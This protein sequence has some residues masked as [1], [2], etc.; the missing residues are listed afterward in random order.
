MVRVELL[1]R[2]VIYILLVFLP[3]SSLGILCT[4]RAAG[5]RAF[6]MHLGRV[7]TVLV[8]RCLGDLRGVVMT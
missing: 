3:V 7:C 5:S 1:G 8:I 4:R 6:L 2:V